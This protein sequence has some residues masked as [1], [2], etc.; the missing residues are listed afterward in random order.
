MA[1]AASGRD[2][3]LRAALADAAAPNV[4]PGAASAGDANFS[5]GLA[6]PD[7]SPNTSVASDTYTMEQAVFVLLQIT[8]ANLHALENAFRDAGLKN[9]LKYRA[10]FFEQFLA[11][12]SAGVAKTRIQKV[13]AVMVVFMASIQKNKDRVRDMANLVA[14]PGLRAGII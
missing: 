11:P 8:E 4:L 6:I 7:P 3:R 14:E 1:A 9:A 2:H 12:N 10:A 13:S 5:A